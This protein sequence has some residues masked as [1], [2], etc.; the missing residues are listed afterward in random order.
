[1]TSHDDLLRASPLPRSE[2][3]ALLAA[4]SG[5]SRE[6]LIGHGDED[7]APA[8]ATAFAA[9]EARRQAG[10][11]FAYLLGTRE[12]HGRDFAVGPE[13]LI[14]RHETELLVELALGRLRPDAAVLELGTGSGCLA[15]TLAAERAD[16]RLDA[17]ELAPAALAR[18]RAN[19][20]RHEVDARIRWHP[21]PGSACWW[22]ADLPSDG[23][24]LILSNPPY[25][26]AADPHLGRDDLRFEPP[27]A[28]SDGSADGLDSLRAIAAG[29]PA[30]LRPGGWLLLEHGWDQG[31]A[32]RDLLEAAGLGAV[33][34]HPDLG[35]RDRVTLGRR[36]S[37]GDAHPG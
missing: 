22:P 19:A 36:A 33:A 34:T 6:W 13:V 26:A 21:S 25:I 30:H 2:A 18:A 24:D 1:M 5:R 3:R 28:L 4:V 31:A 27:G 32:V 15:V 7:V 9:L 10:E 12:F 35:G 29:A 17:T 20:R 23:F 37:A 8:V 11:P 14:P 16:L